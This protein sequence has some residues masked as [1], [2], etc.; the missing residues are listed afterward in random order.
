MRWRRNF[1]QAIQGLKSNQANALLMMLGIIVGIAS[2]TII[3]AIG[4]GTKK[5]VLNRITSL[6]FGP[7]AFSIYSGAGRLFFR[8]AAAP[9]SMTFQDVDDIRD[10][11]FVRT[12]MP[13]QRKRMN[14]FYRKRFTNT[15]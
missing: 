7:E 11:P 8:K 12:A 6:G 2:L 5:K 10:L 13:R 15:R 9:T 3:V 4:E 1:L 14:A